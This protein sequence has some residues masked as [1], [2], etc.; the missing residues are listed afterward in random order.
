MPTAKLSTSR[1]ILNAFKAFNAKYD[2]AYANAET[3]EQREQLEATYNTLL[4][5]TV[6]RINDELA[7]SDPRIEELTKELKKKSQQLKQ[8]SA[9]TKGTV[10]VIGA[11]AGILRTI[12]DIFINL[13]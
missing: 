7:L 8:M 13:A 3:Q 11:A 4:T 2:V 5:A 10:A 12:A 1:E 6:K 9:S